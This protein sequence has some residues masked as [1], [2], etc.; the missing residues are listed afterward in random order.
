V[1]ISVLAQVEQTAIASLTAPT[2]QLRPDL[3]GTVD[4]EALRMHPGDLDLQPLIAHRRG[5]G[6]LVLAAS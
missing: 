6:G 2:V 1:T 3:A 4:T 5:D